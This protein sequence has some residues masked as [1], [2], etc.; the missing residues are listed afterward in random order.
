MVTRR[1]IKPFPHTVIDGFLSPELVARINREWPQ[2]WL[3]EQGKYNFK[4]SA[5]E[6]PPAAQ[7]A[8]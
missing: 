2:D 6:L 1:Y 3:K 7:E 8:A 5:Q 4:W